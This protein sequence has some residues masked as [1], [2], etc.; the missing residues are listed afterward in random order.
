MKQYFFTVTPEHDRKR[1]DQFLVD[2]LVVESRSSLQKH[3]LRGRVKL[4]EHVVTKG[5]TLVHTGDQVLLV[6]ETRFDRPVD[7]KMS[8]D[9]FEKNLVFEGKHFLVIDKPAGL[10]VHPTS[11]D[12]VELALTDMLRIVFPETKDVGEFSRPGIVH[13]LDKLTSGLLL[14]A[15]TKHGYD[16]LRKLFEG[17]GVKKTYLALVVG[18]PPDAETISYNI[19]RDPFHPTRMVCSE[20]VGSHAQTD[21]ETIRRFDGYALIRAFPRTGR[22]HQIRLHCAQAGFPILGDSIYGNPLPGAQ[23]FGLHAARLQFVFDG[24]EY[25]FESPIPDDFKKL[26]ELVIKQ[27]L[28]Y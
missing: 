20:I 24:D 16:E 19:T 14:I 2:V 23:R 1:L 10:L 7:A 8:Q 13:R 17:R 15:R 4:N 11:E 22:T 28:I 21:L 5:G 12:S 3:I 25:Q 18:D 6:I 27:G 26:A 9:F